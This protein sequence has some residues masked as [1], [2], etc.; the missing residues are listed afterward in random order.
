MNSISR[1]S[2]GD[3]VYLIARLSCYYYVEALIKIWDSLN[4]MYLPYH[5]FEQFEASKE[6]IR[7]VNYACDQ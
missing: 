5:L 4:R 1:G 6:N 3:T 7:V 2:Q